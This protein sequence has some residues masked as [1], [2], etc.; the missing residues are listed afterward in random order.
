MIGA[1]L[2]RLFPPKLGKI[3]DVD[4][5]LLALAIREGQVEVYQGEE[6]KPGRVF[7]W[8]DGRHRKP[9]RIR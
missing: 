3:E 5:V 1:L 2:G 6:S 8:P 9:L 7:E 4:T